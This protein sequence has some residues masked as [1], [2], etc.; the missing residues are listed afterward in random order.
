MKAEKVES[1]PSIISTAIAAPGLTG[2]DGFLHHQHTETGG[3]TIPADDGKVTCLICSQRFRS[4]AVHLRSHDMTAEEY[5]RGH[6]D[7]LIHGPGAR[8]G[9]PR[10]TPADH[11][12]LEKNVVSPAISPKEVGQSE[13]AAGQSNMPETGWTVEAVEPIIFVCH[14]LLASVDPNPDRGADWQ[15]YRTASTRLERRLKVVRRSKRPTHLEIDRAF[16]VGILQCRQFGVVECRRW[17]DDI[18]DTEVARGLEAG[19]IEPENIDHIGNNEWKWYR[20]QAFVEVMGPLL[21]EADKEW[22]DWCYF[23][24]DP[25]V[26]EPEPERAIPNSVVTDASDA[27]A[28]PYGDIDGC[29]TPDAVPAAA[30]TETASHPDAEN[31]ASITATPSVPRTPISR[32]KLLSGTSLQPEPI[33]WIWRGWLAAGKLHLLAGA[34]SS[35]KTTM[36]IGFASTVTVGGCWPDG[37]VA[38]AGHVLVWS[39]EDDPADSLLPRFLAGGGDPRLIH[40]VGHIAEDGR[41]RP[42]DPARDFGDLVSAARQLP[43]LRLIILDPLVSAVSADSHRNA[44][45]RRCL[46]PVVDAATELGC[47]VLGITHFTK[48]TQGRDPLDRVT[49]SLAFG[50]LARLVMCTARPAGDGAKR[51]LVRAKSNIGPDGD[52]FEFDL[53]DMMIPEHPGVAGARVVWGDPLEGHARA[54]LAEVEKPSRNDVEAASALGEAERFLLDAL[55]SGPVPAIRIKGDAEQIG[56]AWKTVRNAKASLGIQSVKMGM[57]AGWCWTRPE[58]AHDAPKVPANAQEASS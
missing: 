46:Q 16:A 1:P 54:L 21:S 12:S 38:D 15:A 44:E 49:G 9:R 41:R 42:F 56:L 27:V 34:P 7:A 40:F 23:E 22:A 52:G 11:P 31:S 24:D 17:L 2:G 8:G 14:S 39:A 20:L 13:D 18:I 26:D 5:R 57:E 32:V 29:E 51:R 19:E 55:A 10:K 4:L 36:A 33:Q 25:V 6:P 50:A 53:E 37:T 45:V 48:G 35:G 47:A 3:T 43:G 58:D 28:E 30:D